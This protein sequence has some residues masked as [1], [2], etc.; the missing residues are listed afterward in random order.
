MTFTISPARF[1]DLNALRNLEKVVFKEDAWP[2]V[3]LLSTLLMPGGI[4]YKAESDGKVIGFISAEN[5]LFEKVTWVTTVGVI[6]E[7][8]NQGVGFSLMR[9]VE[10]AVNRPSIK[11]CVRKSNR[12][13]IHLYEKLGYHKENTRHH[14]YSDGE[15]AYVMVMTMRTMAN[16]H[17]DH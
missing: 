6:P 1:R 3:D 10:D 16:P 11:L 13:A 2:V 4:H 7:Y 12:A 5:N 15:D 17:P 9:A 14:Y 8:Q